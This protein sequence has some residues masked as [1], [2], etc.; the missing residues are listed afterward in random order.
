[1]VFIS[2]VWWVVN[3]FRICLINKGK[4]NIIKFIEL[5]DGK[6]ILCLNYEEIEGNYLKWLRR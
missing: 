4:L 3:F 5:L 1:M 2:N 6:Y